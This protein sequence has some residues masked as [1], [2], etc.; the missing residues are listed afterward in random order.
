MAIVAKILDTTQGC[1]YDN[2]GSSLNV[3]IVGQELVSLVK[4]TS[5]SQVDGLNT[6]VFRW[7]AVFL[8]QWKSIVG[9]EVLLNRT[10]VFW[11]ITQK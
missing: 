6:I 1:C 8:E 5:L 11:K 10:K 7:E 2:W 3:I 9:V 4:S